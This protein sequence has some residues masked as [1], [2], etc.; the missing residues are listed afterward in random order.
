MK[1][2]IGPYISRKTCNLVDWWLER[3]YGEHYYKL[4]DESFTVLDNTIKYIDHLLQQLYNATIN[5]Y[6]EAQSRKI[7]IRI[8]TYDLY[9]ADITMAMLIHPILVALKKYKNGSPTVDD[10]D[11]PEHLRSHNGIKEY[12]TDSLVHARFDYVIDEMIWA[13]SQLVLE[14]TG[15]D[16]SDFYETGQFTDHGMIQRKEHNARIQNGLR[17]FGKY[18]RGLWW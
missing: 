9:N 8:D 14:D 12:G 7:K 10:E 16:L 15:E 1:V 6:Y 18:Y 17:L 5:R 4:S 13:F 11:A 2:Y 3:R